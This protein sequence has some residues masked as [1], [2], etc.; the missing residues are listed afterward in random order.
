MSELE[1][2]VSN[3]FAYSFLSAEERKPSTPSV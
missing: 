1:K 3:S 2:L